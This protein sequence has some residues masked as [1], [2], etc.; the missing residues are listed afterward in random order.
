MFFEYKDILHL[1][2]Y[3]HYYDCFKEYKCEN[4]GYVYSYKS[5]K[6]TLMFY[7]FDIIF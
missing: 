2:N 7:A 1:H 4:Y 5:Y 3:D 6:T